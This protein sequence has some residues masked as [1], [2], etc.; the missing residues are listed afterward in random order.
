MNKL[1]PSTRPRRSRR[2]KFDGNFQAQKVDES[3]TLGALADAAVTAAV[4]T[5]AL[6]QDSFAISADLIWTLSGHTAGQG[7]ISV[8]FANQSL[9]TTQIAEAVDATPSS[10]SDTIARERARRPVRMVGAFP[11]LLS[12]EA[13]NNGNMFRS[14]LGISLAN[15]ADLEIWARNQSGAPLTTGSIIKVFGKLFIRWT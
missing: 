7:P 3:L 15:S 9:S 10:R 5:G 4:I 11:G 12:E 13:L 8:G 14:R 2:R 6:A 1:P